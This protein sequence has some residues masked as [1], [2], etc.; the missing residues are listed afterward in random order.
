MTSYI[1]PPNKKS[2]L[3]RECEQE[4]I[5]L[6]EAYSKTYCGRTASFREALKAAQKKHRLE[7]ELE[8]GPTSAVARLSVSCDKKSSKKKKETKE[9]VYT[10][11]KAAS[12]AVAAAKKAASAANDAKERASSAAKFKWTGGSFEIPETDVNT[13]TAAQPV[14]DLLSGEEDGE[15]CSGWSSNDESWNSAELAE[16]TFYSKKA[17][18]CPPTKNGAAA[19][20]NKKRRAEQ[21]TVQSGDSSDDDVYY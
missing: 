12:A 8:E 4:L 15:S 16:F 18:S 2:K 19:S 7:M 6:Q 11:K 1:T 10:D 13:F 17:V 21:N 5:E 9:K 20:S 14:I 3:D